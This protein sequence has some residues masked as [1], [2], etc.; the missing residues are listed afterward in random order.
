MV[1]ALN[2]ACAL[3]ERQTSVA[4]ASPSG[5][6]V[7]DQA[8]PYPMNL[9]EERR[10]MLQMV[11]APTEKFL[12]EV[13]DP[14]ANDENSKIPMEHLKQFAELGAFGALVP[15]E[16]EV[17]LRVCARG[18]RHSR[19]LP[20]RGPQQHANGAPRGGRRRQRPRPR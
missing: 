11:L 5:R 17:R 16:Y 3:S 7:L 14:F 20:G 9:D 6:A 2:S 19:R 13:N 15:E 4:A 12:E 8:F 10:E 18:T 1:S